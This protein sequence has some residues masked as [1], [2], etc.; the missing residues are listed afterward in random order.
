[1]T[2]SSSWFW[3]DVSDRKNALA[4]IDESFWVTMLLAALAA[5]STFI[6]FARDWQADDRLRGF[7]G[8]AFLVG[9]G[10]GIRQKSRIAAVA[11]FALY[12]VARLAQWV[13]SGHS[14]SII[15]LALASLARWHGVRGTFAF[16][17]FASIAAG[18][19]SIEGSFCSLRQPT[20]ETRQKSE[21]K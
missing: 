16:H 21:P 2:L 6:D 5:V 17:H 14:G 20:Q 7:A 15:F 12:V 1:M 3:P 4:A 9:V 19:P 10:L 8:T 13:A 18:T 11:G